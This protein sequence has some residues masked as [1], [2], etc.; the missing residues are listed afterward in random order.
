MLIAIL[1]YIVIGVILEEIY[2]KFNDDHKFENIDDNDT[3]KEK[4]WRMMIRQNSTI[5]LVSR[6]LLVLLMPL[7]TLV[8]IGN[9]LSKV[10]KK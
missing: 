2:I 8:Y 6:L 10:I 7:G 5:K 9:I 1:I 3:E 4:F